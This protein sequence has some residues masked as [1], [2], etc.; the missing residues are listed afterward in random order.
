MDP[1]EIVIPFTNTENSSLWAQDEQ[2]QKHAVTSWE[3]LTT[4]T[5]KTSGFS[6]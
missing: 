4:D 1:A 3:R 2:W 6:S 5:L